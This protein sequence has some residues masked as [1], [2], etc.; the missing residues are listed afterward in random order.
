MRQRPC[1]TFDNVHLLVGCGKSFSMPSN[2][3]ANAFAFAMTI[4]LLQR[5]RVYIWF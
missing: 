1:T 4:W 3:A 2:H 5:S